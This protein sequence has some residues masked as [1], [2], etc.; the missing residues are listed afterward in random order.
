MFFSSDVTSQGYLVFEYDIPH[1][2]NRRLYPRFV[3]HVNGMDM[4]EQYWV[5]FA[6]LYRA[7]G[8]LSARKPSQYTLNE[9]G[10]LAGAT[11]FD[12]ESA[13]EERWG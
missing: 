3:H 12:L 8:G 4:A 7:Q 13:L 10:F 5:H 6:K 9:G 11:K 1:T 2:N